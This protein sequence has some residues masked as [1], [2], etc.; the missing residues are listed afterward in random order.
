MILLGAGWG[1]TAAVAC[2]HGS[3]VSFAGLLS[4]FHYTAV[5]IH[6]KLIIELKWI[7]QKWSLSVQVGRGSNA[8]YP[9]GIALV[10]ACWGNGKLFGTKVLPLRW[11]TNAIHNLRY[12]CIK[13]FGLSSSCHHLYLV[14]CYVIWHNQTS[15]LNWLHLQVSHFM[16]EIVMLIPMNVF[17]MLESL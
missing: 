3:L 10:P 2:A 7:Y 14:W 1:E 15:K 9:C 11:P 4:A 17:S 8:L 12:I 5:Q 6:A 16:K 13:T